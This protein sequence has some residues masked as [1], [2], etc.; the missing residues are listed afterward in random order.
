MAFLGINQFRRV[1][2][3]F[4]CWFYVGNTQRLTESGFMEKPGIKPVTPGLQGIGLSL[5]PWRRLWFTKHRLI[6]C[7]KK[8]FVAFLGINQFCPGW[9]KICVLVLWREHPKA[10]QKLFYGEAGN[11]TCDPWFT[12][13]KN[14]FVAFPWVVTSTGSGGVM[15]CVLLFYDGNSRSLKGKWFYWEEEN[16]TCHPWFTRYRLIPYTFLWLSWVY[17]SSPGLV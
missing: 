1:G 5:T 15:I 3:R 16:Q 10:H 9:F 12:R 14:F 11:R 17:P 13:Q 4:V 7:A 6:P 2:L 8:L